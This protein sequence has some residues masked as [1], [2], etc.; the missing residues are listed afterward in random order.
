MSNS[1]FANT[2]LPD[3]GGLQAPFRTAAT[4]RKRL[5]PAT[6]TPDRTADRTET[7]ANPAP[8]PESPPPVAYRTNQQPSNEFSN[9]LKQKMRPG[10]QQNAQVAKKHTNKDDRPETGSAAIEV[11]ISIP[12]VL[13][14][15]TFAGADARGQKQ[16]PGQTLD[17]DKS[18]PLATL[19]ETKDTSV[20]LKGT[21]V[22]LPTA[23]KTLPS[24]TDQALPDT[25][26]STEADQ[27]KTEMIAPSMSGEQSQDGD[28]SVSMQVSD[29]ADT[30]K[31]LLPDAANAEQQEE[32]ADGKKPVIPGEPAPS[33]HT[34]VEAPAKAAL[35]SINTPKPNQPAA[36]DANIAPAETSATPAEQLPATTSTAASDNTAAQLPNKASDA[37]DE[38]GS[39][40]PQNATIH[41]ENFAKAAKQITPQK[42]VVDHKVSPDKTELSDI[43]LK[44][45]SDDGS[46]PVKAIAQKAGQPGSGALSAQTDTT[47]SLSVGG[48]ESANADSGEPTVIGNTPPIGITEQSTASSESAK[49]AA[50]ADSQLSVADQIMEPVRTSLSSGS[51]QVDIQLNPP[52]LGKVNITFREDADGITGLL[53]VSE[54]QTRQQIQQELPQIIQ[55]LQDS[56]IQIKKLDVE[57]TDQQQQNNPKDQSATTGQDAWTGQ[58]GTPNFQSQRDN[59]PY[60]EWLTN[61]EPVTEFS[62]ARM[63]FAD[64]SINMLA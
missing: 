31:E 39:P 60:N 18:A 63:Q 23:K 33:P 8:T 37:K 3:P 54:P 22:V 26:T 9:T 47:G 29:K 38:Q 7:K 2:F 36:A 27:P 34:Q 61:N 53:Q 44:T 45:T 35:T 49:P 40:L 55:N 17:K 16:I 11:A 46:A 32:T 12:V 6:R 41:A 62:E 56:G 1:L 21:P 50:N 30:P 42:A 5:S 24:K 28:D 13:D 64:S 43:Q 52:E 58:Q 51:R 59:T 10:T 15:A 48:N 57:L 25:A 19:A 4:T 20:T 14:K